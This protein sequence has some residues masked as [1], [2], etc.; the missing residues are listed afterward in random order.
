MRKGLSVEEIK[1]RLNDYDALAKDYMYLCA[2]YTNLTDRL[3]KLMF[4]L[5]HVALMYLNV[6]SSDEA[7]DED[8]IEFNG[9]IAGLME[10]KKYLI[11]IFKDCAGEEETDNDVQGEAEGDESA[12]GQEDD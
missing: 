8:R 1:N 7:T 3:A 12:V 10:A 6:A 9:K 2:E 4:Y 5:D 11:D